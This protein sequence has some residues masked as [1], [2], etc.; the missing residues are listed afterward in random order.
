MKT[1]SPR[2]LIVV[3]F[4][5]NRQKWELDITMPPGST[6]ARLKRL[7]ETEAEAVTEGEAR[8]AKVEAAWAAAEPV[9]DQQMTLV[10]AFEKYFEAKA[11]KKSLAEDKRLAE[12]LKA[13]FGTTTRLRDITASKIAAYTGKRLSATSVRRKDAD[14][15][16]AR[17]SAASI[18]RPLALLRHL[19]RIA[20][21][22]WEV[23]PKV[24]VVRLE[25]EPEGHIRW[26]EPDE[27]ARLLKA[28]AESKNPDL[29]PIVT[30]AL[31]TGLRKG[32]LLG[33]TWDRIDLSRGVIRLEVTKS[34]KRREVPMR[35]QV[36]GILSKHP[37]PR[38]GRVWPD[39]DIRSAFETAVAKSG[40][41]NF[42]L[43]STRHHFA[44]WFVMRGGDLL[45]LQ[46]ILGHRTLAMT[47]RYAHLSPIICAARWLARSALMFSQPVLEPK[48]GASGACSRWRLWKCLRRLEPGAG[49]EPATY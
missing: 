1:A 47:Q 40:L 35:Q 31:E 14:G 20:A 26:L 41:E 6:P 34:G 38:E 13:H 48:T 27:E 16:P 49:V 3:R 2:R 7:F 46:K 30:V 37:E 43:H 21:V 4:R 25:K 24:P 11:R 42:T 44:S 23:I 39:V 8:R 22:Q 10:Q 29:L 18:N 32:E 28:C 9:H 36:Y 45:A 17:L 15:Q 19:L 33:L 12:H 5:K